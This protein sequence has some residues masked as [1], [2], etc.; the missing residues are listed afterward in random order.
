MV[1]FW[2]ADGM[3][4]GPPKSRCAV[5]FLKFFVGKTFDTE[6]KGSMI[7]TLTVSFSR[8]GWVQP[9]SHSDFGL[10]RGILLRFLGT[11]LS[12]TKLLKPLRGLINIPSQKGQLDSLKQT[13]KHRPSFTKFWGF[14]M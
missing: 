4:N 1:E 8:F 2:V 6:T 11:P 3:E 13:E 9:P 12:H 5:F 14:K 10:S 7:V